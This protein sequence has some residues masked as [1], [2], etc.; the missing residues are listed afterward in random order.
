M[1]YK[2]IFLVLLI[3]FLLP[4]GEM[5]KQWDKPS[6]GQKNDISNTENS[7]VGIWNI[8]LDQIVAEYRKT[9][10]YKESGEFAELGVEMIKGIFSL[11]KFEFKNNGTYILMGVPT[12]TGQT[13]SFEG[14]WY[15]ENGFIILESVQKGKATENITFKLSGADLLI[16]QDEG[17]EMFYLIREK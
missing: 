17:G 12:P 14:N 15:K 16:P 11:M 5:P 9:P 3:N 1:K 13:E 4:L 7:I 6:L 2:V 10:E 8:D